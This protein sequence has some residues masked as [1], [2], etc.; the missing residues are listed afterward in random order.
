MKRGDG[1][2]SRPYRLSQCFLTRW[3]YD[4]AHRCLE[5]TKSA[6]GFCS[7]NKTDIEA[8]AF[9]KSEIR[10][11]A[12]NKTFKPFAYAHSDASTPHS[13][14][15]PTAFFRKLRSMLAAA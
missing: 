10:Q 9:A 13:L 1:R 4:F 8:S 12:L 14:R 5:R 6:N 7:G 11:S 3:Q 2:K 15:V